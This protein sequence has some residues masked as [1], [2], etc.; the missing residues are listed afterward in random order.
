MNI[1]AILV[2]TVV[3]QVI[4]GFWYSPLLFAKVW[5]RETGLTTEAL[6]ASPSKMP[7]VVAIVSALVLAVALAMIHAALAAESAWG[8]LGNGLWVGLVTGIGV[9]A[10]CAAPHY[11]FTGRSRLL[12]LIDH[13]HSLSWCVVMSLIIALWR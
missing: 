5:M 13:G 7:F 4:G 3:A 10:A 8:A 6:K 12:F 11:A 9:A 1:W 2:A